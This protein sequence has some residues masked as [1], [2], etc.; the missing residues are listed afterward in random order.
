MQYVFYCTVTWPVNFKAAFLFSLMYFIGIIC[1]YIT[2][3]FHKINNGDYSK[4]NNIK[5]KILYWIWAI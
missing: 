4:C 2:K 1:V 5:Y 3:T